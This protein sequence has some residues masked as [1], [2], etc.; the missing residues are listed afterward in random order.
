M[1]EL[2][3]RKQTFCFLQTMKTGFLCVKVAF[4]VVV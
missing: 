1:S 2:L 3:D 4:P